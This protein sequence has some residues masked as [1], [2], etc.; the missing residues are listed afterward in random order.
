MTPNVLEFRRG[1]S[2]RPPSKV[3]LGCCSKL[4]WVGSQSEAVK[5]DS[6]AITRLNDKLD[7]ER[8]RA[9]DAL[10]KERE[11]TDRI[12]DHLV[13]K[14]GALVVE[15]EFVKYAGGKLTIKDKD[16]KEAP[17][18]LDPDAEV[19]IK[20]QP[21]KR[22]NLTDLKPGTRLSVLVNEG[23]ALKIRTVD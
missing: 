13:I 4:V 9:E 14:A 7:T 19:T 23:K 8:Q 5:R 12:L 20:G 15:G 3:E 10:S 6:E 16:G 21:A 22:E 17:F 18:D 2:A 1:P 11:R